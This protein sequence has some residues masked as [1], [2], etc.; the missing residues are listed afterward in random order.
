MVIEIRIEKRT[1]FIKEKMENQTGNKG[2]ELTRFKLQSKMYYLP[3]IILPFILIIILMHVINWFI[4]KR[5]V[6]IAEV[7]GCVECHEYDPELISVNGEL[8]CES[9]KRH[10]VQKLK[11]GLA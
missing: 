10:Y 2:K 6:K 1:K 11:E 9:C 8:V 3:I 7:Y 5:K 4:V